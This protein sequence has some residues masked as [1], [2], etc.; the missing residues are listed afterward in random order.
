MLLSC[1]FRSPMLR[2]N[3]RINVILPT[4]EEEDAPLKKDLKV[5]YLLHGLHGDADS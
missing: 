1:H 5:L 4:P 3:T 2:R